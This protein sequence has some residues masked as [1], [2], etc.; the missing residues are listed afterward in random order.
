MGKSKNN[1]LEGNVRMVGEKV[2]IEG[3][4]RGGVQDGGFVVGKVN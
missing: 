2:E 1:V 4:F 3:V